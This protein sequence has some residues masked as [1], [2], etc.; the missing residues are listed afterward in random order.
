MDSK[1]SF[2]KALR[3]HTD[4]LETEHDLACIRARLRR[5]QVR[6]EVPAN[7][8]TPW[9]QDQQGNEEYRCLG[10]LIEALD[11]MERRDPRQIALALE[12]LRPS[13]HVSV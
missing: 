4:G 13:A 2:W 12:R 3:T 8:R 1:N 5:A 6:L 11:G 10:A 9:E 7:P